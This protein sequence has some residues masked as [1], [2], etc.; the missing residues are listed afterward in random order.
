MGD[1]L[2]SW[3]A[4]DGDTLATLLNRLDVDLDAHRR[5]PS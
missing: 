1:V 3:S 2:A 5:L 4:E